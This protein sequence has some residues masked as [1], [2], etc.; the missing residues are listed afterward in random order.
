MLAAVSLSLLV[1]IPLGV[2][3]GRSDRFH[4]A[5]TPVLDAMQIIPAFAYL[6]PIVILFS[7]GPG[8]AVI[9]TMIYAIPPAIRITALG[10]RGV[11]AKHGRGRAGDGVDEATDPAEGAAA[12]RTTDAAP[13]RQPDDS[14]RALDGRHRRADRRQGPRRRRD[15][16]AELVPRPRD[17]RRDRDRRHGDGARPDH[18]GRRRPYGSDSP[19]PH[20][21]APTP[22]PSRV[23]RDGG[24]IGGG[25][26]RQPECSAPLPTTRAG[27]PETGFS[28]GSSRCST[29]SANPDTF[30]FSITSWIGDTIIK[31]GLRAAAQLSRPDALVHRARRLHRDRARGQRLAAGAHDIPHART[32]RSHRAVGAGDG[33]RLAGARGDG[34]RGRDRAR[35]R[36]PRR[37]RARDSPARF[38]P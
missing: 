23:D 17:P 25:S 32:D 19:P 15:E 16:R 24:D 18:R 31:Y 13:R 30:L 35:A 29:T 10:I 36:H 6:M 2:A 38:A 28:P 11:S 27:P 21:R 14:V 33:H 8:A 12:A 5:I 1:G 22:A 34:A 4:R 3:A 26:R 9:T 37:R 7:V 20:A